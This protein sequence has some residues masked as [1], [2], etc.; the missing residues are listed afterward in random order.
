MLE[1]MAKM[2]AT[3]VRKSSLPRRKEHPDRDRDGALE[4]HRPR[5]VADGQGVFVI[6]EPE[7]RVELL[8]QLRRQR[9][10]D[11]CDQAGGD[12][13]GLGE[14]L[15]GA[16]EE[17]GAE[18][19]HD[20]RPDQLRGDGPGRPLRAKGPEREPGGGIFF[21][22][23]TL[24]YRPSPRRGRKRPAAPQRGTIFSGRGRGKRPAA[25]AGVKQTRKNTRSGM[26]VCLSA[27]ISLPVSLRPL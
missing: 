1:R 19:H 11:E 13:Y 6:P 25:A 10:E 21:G 7:N 14:M 23:P 5:D 12:S 2:A 15:Y 8:R 16:D 27:V 24:L 4:D 9:R 18:G 26:A 3:A 22:L 20:D 17:V